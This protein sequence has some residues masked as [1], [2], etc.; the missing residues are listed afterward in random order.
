M[1]LDGILGRLQ[2]EGV[3]SLYHDY[4]SGSMADWS[5]QGNPGVGT[6]VYYTKNGVCFYTTSSRINVTSSAELQALNYTVLEGLTYYP[7]P[8]T[9]RR[10]FFG[11]RDAGS[12]QMEMYISSLTAITVRSEGVT[13][14]IINQFEPPSVLTI[15]MSLANGGQP[16]YYRNGNFIGTLTLNSNIVPNV[17]NLVI[18]NAS[19]VSGNTPV[20]G[21]VHY[22]VYVSRVLSAAEHQELY[23]QLQRLS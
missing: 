12:N 23:Q 19:P 11:K 15:G 3:L 18:G 16:N 14:A 6:D 1:G 5:G 2:T 20:Y 4:R 21:V 9:P 10:T 8:I 7:N 22:F 17:G 13:H